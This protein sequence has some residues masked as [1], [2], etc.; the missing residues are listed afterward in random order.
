MKLAILICTL[1]EPFYIE[2]LKRL[3]AELDR[4]IAPHADKV[5]YRIH[6]A[7]RSMTTGQKRNELIQNTNSE[8]FV[9]IDSDDMVSSDYISQILNATASS[10]DCITFRGHMTTDGKNKQGWTIKLGGP[11]ITQNNYHYRW[12]NH[13]SV[14]RRDKVA[15]IKF[16][17]K[18]IGEDYDWSKM[19]HDK[20][21][22]LTECHIDRE[23]YIYDF[24]TNKNNSKVKHTRIR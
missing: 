16:P 14:M 13:I 1:N 7:G 2:R 17:N 22:L 3:Q 4:Q 15:H 21:L 20:K 23:M 24:V 6:D 11:Y 10:P 19:I 18:T 8:Y 9:F 5:F 12:P